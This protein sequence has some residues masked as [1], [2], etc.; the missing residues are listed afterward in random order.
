MRPRLLALLAA[1]ASAVAGCDEGAA[2]AGAQEPGPAALVVDGMEPNLSGVWLVDLGEV[3]VG[4]RGE[5]SVV[6]GNVG[7]R[8]AAVEVVAPDAGFEIALGEAHLEPG[9]A[10]RLTV[11]YVAGGPGARAAPATLLHDDGALELWIRA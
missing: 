4:R 3:E 1:V 11:G 10:T 7:G 9:E 8:A 2:V 6:V 5:A